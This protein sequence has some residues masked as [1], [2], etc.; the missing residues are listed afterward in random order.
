[1]CFQHFN[2][3]PHRTAIQN[4]MKGPAQV[5]ELSKGEARDR[6]EELLELLACRQEGPAPEPLRNAKRE[7]TQ[8]FLSAVKEAV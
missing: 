1:M 2:L 4:C 5:L 6:G 8:Q 7:R 3:F